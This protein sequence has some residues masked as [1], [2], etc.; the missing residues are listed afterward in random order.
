MHVQYEFIAYIL[1]KLFVKSHKNPPS[2]ANTPCI[3][4]RGGGLWSKDCRIADA[5]FVVQMFLI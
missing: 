2:N 4:R 5:H 1:I 3:K